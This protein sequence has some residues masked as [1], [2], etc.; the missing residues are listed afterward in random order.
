[1]KMA[2]KKREA[3]GLK[4]RSDMDKDDQKI[5]LKTIIKDFEF[6]GSPHMTWKE[7]KELEDRKVVSLGGK[8][9]KKQRLPLSV[10]RA[11]MKNQKKRDEKML[12]EN[13]ILGRFGGNYGTKNLIEKR[14]PENRVLKSTVGHF[15]NGVLDVKD[16][17]Q[18]SK[19]RNDERKQSFGKGKGKGKKKG[20]KKNAGKKGGKKRH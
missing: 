11:Q 10:A 8:P 5:D 9:P 17:L 20:G 7:R 4:T 15:K 14:R 1:M 3:R 16:L 13:M 2:N 6:L 18:S 19:P 12:Q